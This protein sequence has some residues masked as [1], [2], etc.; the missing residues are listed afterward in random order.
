MGRCVFGSCQ[1]TLVILDDHRGLITQ[2]EFN[3]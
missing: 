1:I 3:G 2:G